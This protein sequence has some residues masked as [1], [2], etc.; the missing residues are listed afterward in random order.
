MKIGNVVIDQNDKQWVVFEFD[1]KFIH[2][3]DFK[4][5]KVGEVLLYSYIKEVIE[6]PKN[7][8]FLFLKRRTNNLRGLEMYLV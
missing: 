4:T 6:M 2:V 7:V 1:E 3:V 8:Q 5:Q